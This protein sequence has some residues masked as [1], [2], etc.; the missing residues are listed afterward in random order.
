[1]FNYC[2]AMLLLKINGLQNALVTRKRLRLQFLFIFISPVQKKA[3][4]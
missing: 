1:M 3:R 2:Y 4:N